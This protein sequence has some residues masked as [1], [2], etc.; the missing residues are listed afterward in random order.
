MKQLLTILILS[1][2]ILC[3]GCTSGSKVEEETSEEGVVI[4]WDE[5]GV[6]EDSV[7]EDIE[8]I[9]DEDNIDNE[10]EVI[11]EKAD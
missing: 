11:E 1:L 7:Y 6:E 4:E 3:V 2:S 8:D 9:K 10:S 5:T